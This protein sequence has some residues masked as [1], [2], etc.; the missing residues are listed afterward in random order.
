MFHAPR[1]DPMSHHTHTCDTHRA[2][3]R[4][5][6]LAEHHDPVARCERELTAR[7]RIER[8]LRLAAGTVGALH[9]HGYLTALARC[10][11]QLGEGGRSAIGGSVELGVSE[12]ELLSLRLQ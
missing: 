4:S 6:E 12:E 5:E 11:G 8:Q 7:R 1:R 3:R 9:S 10:L 2:W